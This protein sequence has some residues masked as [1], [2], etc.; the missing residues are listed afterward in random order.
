[1]QTARFLNVDTSLHVFCG[2]YIPDKATKEISD[3]YWDIT[4]ALEL[5][6]FPLVIPGTKIYRAVQARKTAMYWLKLA[7]H[8]SKIAMANG[9]PPTCM[10]DEWVTIINDPGYKGRKDFSDHEMA[11][12]LFSFLFASQDAMS[13]G[14]IYGFQH[15]VDHPE[16]LAK[17]REEQ[18]RV[19][20]GDYEKP[21][22]LDMYDEM[23]YLKAFVKESLRVKPP[24]LMVSN[25]KRHRCL[26]IIFRL[27]DPIRN[28]ET[29]P[30]LARLHRPHRQH[31][32]PLVLQFHA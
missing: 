23:T 32:H 12:T 7:A 14:L 17:I 15:L 29:F 4:K 5:V 24:V 30:N 11:L 9:A 13:S 26:S 16:I 22:T 10:I 19:R 31:G 27:S 1:M 28:D 25:L 20:Q 21:I 3:K 6:N 8:K 18:E 2:D